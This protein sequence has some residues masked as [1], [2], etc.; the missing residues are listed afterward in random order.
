[1]PAIHGSLS[2]HDFIKA[3]EIAKEQNMELK[4]WVSGIIISEIHK[5]KPSKVIVA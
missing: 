2:N 3:N 1:M 4:E 5:L